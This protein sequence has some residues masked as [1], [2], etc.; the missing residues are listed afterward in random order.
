MVSNGNFQ[1][2]KHCTLVDSLSVALFSGTVKFGERYT[3]ELND[4]LEKI[5]NLEE[6]IH[7]KI[8]NLINFKM[9][10]L[11]SLLWNK[12]LLHFHSFNY[13]YLYYTVTWSTCIAKILIN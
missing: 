7:F 11:V 8:D 9:L 2:S 1:C 13:A 4:Q 3:R 6:Q 12:H 5:D 10:K